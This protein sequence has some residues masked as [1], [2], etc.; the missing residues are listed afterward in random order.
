MENIVNCLSDE[1]I[2]TFACNP[3]A[4]E[5]VDK[6]KHIYSCLNCQAQLN[7][8]NSII[9]CD[10]IITPRDTDVVQSF[11]AKRP[12]DKLWGDIARKVTDFLASSASSL[13]GKSNLFADKPSFNRASVFSVPRSAKSCDTKPKEL[14]I[15]F[16]ATVDKDCSRYWRAELT[17]PNATVDSSILS[18][19]VLDAN[20]KPIKEATLVLLGIP[21]VVSD[22]RAKISITDFRNNFKVAN[23]ALVWD[24][25]IETAGTPVIC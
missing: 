12:H 17:I 11:L 6:A 23:V 8:V 9:K 7:I 25:K 3:T 2:I 4:P 21:L 13:L 24:D 16:A 1:D 22:G 15:I 10:D 19:K 18:I 14:S 20:E 5:Y